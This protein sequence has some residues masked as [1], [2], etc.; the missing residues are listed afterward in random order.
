MSFLSI[1]AFE[2]MSLL[3]NAALT[4]DGYIVDEYGE[5]VKHA[6]APNPQYTPHPAYQGVELGR[7]Y[8]FHSGLRVDLCS[9]EQ[10]ANFKES[11][12]ELAGFK[13]E[14]NSPADQYLSRFTRAAGTQGGPFREFII[15]PN[16]PMIIGPVLAKAVVGHF[17]DF[18]IRAHAW[19]V[20]NDFNEGFY[21]Q[22]MC[23]YQMFAMASDSGM[24]MIS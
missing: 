20:N 17:G 7:V 2:G 15:L 11:L 8:K 22:Y 13:P 19:D 21:K 12:A 4:H 1:V 14:P 16:E 6:V 23:W 10:M 18:R 3:P 5:L 9:L 24:V